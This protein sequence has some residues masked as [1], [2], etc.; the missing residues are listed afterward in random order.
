MKEVKGEVIRFR[1]TTEEK[2]IIR[3]E[4]EKAGLSLTDYMRI[5]IFGK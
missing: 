5:K 2:D 4:A 1:L 3:K